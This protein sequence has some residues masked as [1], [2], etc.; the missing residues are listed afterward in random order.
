MRNKFNYRSLVE[1]M[2]N[3]LLSIEDFQL[4]NINIKK[5]NKL[6]AKIH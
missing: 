5:K 3:S 6:S 4:L 1:N 2:N